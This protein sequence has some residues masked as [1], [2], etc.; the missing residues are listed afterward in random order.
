RSREHAREQIAVG[1]RPLGRAVE[2]EH[3]AHRVVARDRPARLQRHARVA[4]DREIELDDR[5]RGAERGFDVAVAL[6]YHCGL[7]VAAGLELPGW[8]IRREQYRQL[9]DFDRDEIRRV[10]RQIW[11]FGE[12]RCD[13]LA[14]VAHAVPC[15][16]GLAVRLQPLNSG[17]PEIDRRYFGDVPGGPYG[18]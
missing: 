16:N 1:V 12:N 13:R 14:D 11:I 15:Q 5:V 2:L 7:G 9:L 6:A 17:R 10:L 18:D 4:A 8:L 3:V